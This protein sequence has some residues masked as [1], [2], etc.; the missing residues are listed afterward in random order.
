MKNTI[1][2]TVPPDLMKKFKAEA[3]AA[4]NIILPDTEGTSQH[5][6]VQNGYLL[7]LVNMYK[8]NNGVP[9]IPFPVSFSTVDMIGWLHTEGMISPS[10]LLGRKPG[11]PKWQFPGGFRD[12]KET[13]QEAA[14]R[15]YLE[16]VLLDMD[17]SR[18]TPITSNNTLYCYNNNNELFI[19]D[20][21][22]RNSCHKVT[23]SIYNVRLTAEDAANAAAGDDLGEVRLF[24]V[25]EL[26]KDIS[27][28]REI[29]IP[30]FNA[31]V[32][33]ITSLKYEIAFEKPTYVTPKKEYAVGSFDELV[34][35]I[36]HNVVL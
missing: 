24:S 17:V 35:A 20:I 26:C 2:V 5:M 25:E 19:D 29:H 7:A 30:I 33:Y 23:T 10:I 27:E 11:Q 28:M 3:V 34:K 13:S 18:F 36:T 31:F 16:E 15:E 1:E 21:R 8:K 4:T 9:T 22:Y 32:K 6:D 12:P 14:K